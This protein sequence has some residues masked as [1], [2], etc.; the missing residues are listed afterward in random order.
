MATKAKNKSAP[1]LKEQAPPKG[2]YKVRTAGYEFTVTE[3][4]YT[5]IHRPGEGYSDS[6]GADKSRSTPTSRG[7]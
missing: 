4:E 7:R 2:K 3:N 6:I 5:M 1:K